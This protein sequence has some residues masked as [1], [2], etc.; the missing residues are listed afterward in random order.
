MIES[1]IAVHFNGRG[2]SLF[3]GGHELLDLGDQLLPLGGSLRLG[4]WRS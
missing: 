3:V 1:A 4:H 2:L